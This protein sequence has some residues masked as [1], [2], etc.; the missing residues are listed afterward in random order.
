[1]PTPERPARRTL[2]EGASGEEIGARANALCSNSNSSSEPD[3]CPQHHYFKMV[4]L[5]DG[6]TCADVLDKTDCDE[7][8]GTCDNNAVQPLDPNN[9][10]ANDCQ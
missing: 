7:N 5:A 3:G 10:K 2:E 9:D 1:M 8:D 6:A 4:R